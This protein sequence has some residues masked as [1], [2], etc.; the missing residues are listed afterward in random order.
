M[1]LLFYELAFLCACFSLFFHYTLQ[2]KGIF[3][4]YFLFLVW[5]RWKSCFGQKTKHRNK[6]CNYGHYEI[7]KCVLTNESCC[8]NNYFHY[9]LAQTKF[10]KI[11]HKWT[12]YITRPLGLCLYCSSVWISILGFSLIFGYDSW[13]SYFYV[14]LFIGLSFVLTKLL[15][16]FIG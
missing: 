4:R 12:V 6:L 1:G 13:I 11:L 8:R 3:R 14:C 7:I 16:K 15:Y 5:L 2:E 9:I 10:S